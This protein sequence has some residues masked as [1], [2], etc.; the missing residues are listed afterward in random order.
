MGMGTPLRRLIEGCAH[1]AL[2]ALALLAAPVVVAAIPAPVDAVV[3]TP[4]AAAPTVTLARLDADPVPARI[5]AGD[6]NADFIARPG[7]VI[8]EGDAQ[9]RWWRVTVDRGV[10]APA[11]LVEDRA[12][13]VG[14]GA[15]HDRD[16]V[17]AAVEQAA[18]RAVDVRDVAFVAQQRLR[19][20]HAAAGPGREQEARDA[21][22]AQDS[23]S[24]IARSTLPEPIAC[25]SASR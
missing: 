9:P 18:E 14:G 16:Q 5:I 4:V 6:F 2:L 15:E 1:A 25:R 10:D 20:T 7:A 17:T 21:H 12:D 8:D 11:V 13:L 24:C 19:R 3:A 22:L 23:M